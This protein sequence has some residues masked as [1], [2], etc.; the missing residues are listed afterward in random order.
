[1]PGDSGLSHLLQRMVLAK[2]GWHGPHAAASRLQT[3][4]WRDPPDK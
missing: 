4:G 2:T 1:M 3:A